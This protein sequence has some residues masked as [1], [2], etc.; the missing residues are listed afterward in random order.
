MLFC[1]N[2]AQSFL[3]KSLTQIKK[4]MISKFNESLNWRGGE[5]AISAQSLISLLSYSCNCKIE[6]HLK[7]PPFVHPGLTEPSGGEG[8][9]DVICH[10][11]PHILN[12][13]SKQIAPKDFFLICPCIYN[14]LINIQ[15]VLWIDTQNHCLSLIHLL[16]VQI[17]TGLKCCPLLVPCFQPFS[18]WV[19]LFKHLINVSPC[20][21]HRYFKLNTSQ[22][23]NQL[24]FQTGSSTS[25]PLAMNNT[26]S[27]YPSQKP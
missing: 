5:N 19:S 24:S 23:E 12:Q 8:P 13:N 11:G 3:L 17:P 2:L 14:S 25:H 15:K 21:S 26:T 22:T 27:H 6:L 4:D 16:L 7:M 10:R 20:T 18:F 9:W 1:T